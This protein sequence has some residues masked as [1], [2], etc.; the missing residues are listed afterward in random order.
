MIPPAVPPSYDRDSRTD[1]PHRQLDGLFDRAADYVAGDLSDDE[2]RSFV[3][4]MATDAALRQEVA[5]WQSLSGALR[6]HGRPHD[7]LP[8]QEDFTAQ[9][10][11]RLE[12]DRLRRRQKYWT[13]FPRFGLAAAALLT[14]GLAYA[15]SVAN[16]PAREPQVAHLGEAA[17][18]APDSSD[19][20]GMVASPIEMVTAQ[21]HH[22]VGLRVM[23]VANGSLANQ[24]GLEPGDV[25]TA[26]DDRAMRCPWL[27]AQSLAECGPQDVRKLTVFHARQARAQDYQ[28]GYAQLNISRAGQQLGS[29]QQP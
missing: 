22:L 6:K 27:F 1:D 13:W 8:P 14:V 20:M 12:N 3:E 18:K 21:G 5:F 23:R 10:R 4:A 7:A 26:V 24:L 11:Q 25:V 2:D 15:W 17:A 28:V 16:G 19:I 9:L 29:S